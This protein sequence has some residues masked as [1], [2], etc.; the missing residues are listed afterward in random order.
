MRRFALFCAVLAPGA[1]C[2]LVVKDPDRGAVEASAI[3]IEGAAETIAAAAISPDRLM[4]HVKVLA[5]DEYEGRAPGSKG[6][7]LTVAYLERELRAIGLEP[8]NPDGT[9]VQAVP[10]VGLTTTSTNVFRVGGQDLTFDNPTRMT[11]ISRRQ[12]G[13]VA[14]DASEIV[15][16]GHGAEAPEF[17]WDDF[18]GVDVRGKTVVFLVGD[19]PVADANDASKLDERMFGGRAMTYYGRWT[20]KYDIASRKGAA[21]ALIVH[22]T[23][24]AGYGWGVVERSFTRENFDV[25]SDDHAASRVAFEGWLSRQA[26]GELFAACGEDFESLARSAATRGFRAKTLKAAASF[27]ARNTVRSIASRNVIARLPG[28]SRPKEHVLYT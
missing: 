7:N 25:E 9:F 24:G 28:A 27:T 18:A 6:E 11:L 22:D 15:F 5:S 13:E 8:G 3:A 16:V 21:A 19:P 23:A 17:A 4:A 1:A 10:L 12:T 20:Y 14:I 2:V 26:A